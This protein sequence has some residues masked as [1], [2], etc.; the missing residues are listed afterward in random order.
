[1]KCWRWNQW[2]P[3]PPRG[4][5]YLPS[6]PSLPISHDPLYITFLLEPLLILLSVLKVKINR[7]IWKRNR[8]IWTREVTDLEHLR[9]MKEIVKGIQFIMEINVVLGWTKLL[10]MYSN[11]RWITVDNII[12]ED[13]TLCTI[14]VVEEVVT[15]THELLIIWTELLPG[16]RLWPTRSPPEDLRT[17]G[18][19]GLGTWEPGLGP[20]RID[21]IHQ[22][23]L[24]FLPG[25]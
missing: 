1:M 17:W 13:N 6:K 21:P 8:T 4:T 5:L 24:P 2:A 10:F 14:E 16:L 18:A 9:L 11:S 20:P 23:T 3:P 15:Y 22:T 19:A 12:T 25:L 7:I